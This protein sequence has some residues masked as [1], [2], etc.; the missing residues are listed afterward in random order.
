MFGVHLEQFGWYQRRILLQQ[1][2][3]AEEAVVKSDL[4]LGLRIGLRN[5]QRCKVVIHL[6]HADVSFE[7]FVYPG[8]ND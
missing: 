2:L 4:I 5:K 8:G 6:G 1:R 3:V 7:V